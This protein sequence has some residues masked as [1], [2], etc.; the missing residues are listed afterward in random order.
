LPSRE[1]GHP[2]GIG[3]KEARHREDGLELG[4]PAFSEVRDDSVKG[5][6]GRSS[7]QPAVCPHPIRQAPASVTPPVTFVAAPM[8][9]SPGLAPALSAPPKKPPTRCRL[10]RWPRLSRPFTGKPISLDLQEADIKNV[11]RLLADVSG[12]NI[13]IEPDVAGK[14]T[15]KVNRV[16][17]DQ[18]LDMILAMNNLGQEQAAG[19]IRIARQEKTQKR[20]QTNGNVELKARQQVIESARRLGTFR[21]IIFR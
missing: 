19:V 3:E 1:G 9:P 2:G 7:R 11:L 18:V 4:L 16:P 12:A 20:A 14:V 21:P 17:W 10:Q 5:P 8:N 13:V 15:L 6:F